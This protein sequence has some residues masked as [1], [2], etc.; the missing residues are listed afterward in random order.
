LPL[1]PAKQQTALSRERRI[2]W[3]TLARRQLFRS[4]SERATVA[5]A[6]GKEADRGDPRAPHLL[7]NARSQTAVPLAKRA[8]YCRLCLRQRSRPRCPAST[9]SVG[10]RQLADGC[11]AREASGL[12]LPLPPAKKQTA[13][14][15]ERRICWAT[16]TRQRLFRSRSERATVAFASGKVADRVALRA[17]PLL[18]NASSQKA[19]PLAKRAGYCRLCLRQSSRP[20]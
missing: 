16:P 18:G 1:P 9:A 20:R 13:A 7:G 5:F 17:P 2:C 3:A 4:R 6:S 8:G 12:L 15:C 10:Q 14:S 11:S 19:V